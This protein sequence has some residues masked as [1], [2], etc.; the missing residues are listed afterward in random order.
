MAEQLSNRIQTTLNGTINNSVTTLV[1]AS[2]TGWPATGNFRIRIDDEIML[3]GARSGTTFSS[4]TRAAELVNNAAVAATHLDGAVV[5]LILTKDALEQRVTEMSDAISALAVETHEGE[6]NPHPGYLLDSTFDAKGD[7]IAASADNTPAKVTVGSD[8]FLLKADSGATPGVSW[9]SPAGID[10]GA[11]P[12]SLVD[13]KGD[14]IAATADNTVARKAAGADGTF[15][16][17][18][19]AN[20]DGLEWYDHEGAADPH[21]G[22][23]LESLLDA[24]GDGIFASAD[25]TPAKVTVGTNGKVLTADSSATAGVSWQDTTGGL[26]SSV[27]NK[28]YLAANFS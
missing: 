22:Y 25:N 7:M 1:V 14:I 24:K 11:I 26:A 19:A 15:L 21:T 8:G 23:V 2:G 17:P 13:V 28:L 16:R 6:L 27:G 18:K 9:V 4:I 5:S 12:K 10:T 20:S 3:V